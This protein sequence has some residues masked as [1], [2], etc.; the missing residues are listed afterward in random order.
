MVEGGRSPLLSREKLVEMGF[1]FIIYPVAAMAASAAA[2]N[3]AYQ[4]LL[5]GGPDGAR[6]GFQELNRMVGF[7][8]K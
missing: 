7:L 1:S 3:A 6:V 2:L 4:H 8:E 5:E